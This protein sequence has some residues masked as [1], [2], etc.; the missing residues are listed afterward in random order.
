LLESN[1]LVNPNPKQKKRSTSNT[2][3][4]PSEKLKEDKESRE[5]ENENKAKEY[6]I[7]QG[8]AKNLCLSENVQMFKIQ[9]MKLRTELVEFLSEGIMNNKSLKSLIVNN[10]NL[11]NEAYEILIKG[12][13]THES[14]EFLDLSYNKLNDK[15]GN[16]IARIIS[17]Q[18]QRRDQVVWMYGL[19]NERPLGN[20]YTKGLISINLSHNQ[21]SDISAE[22][23]SLALSHDSYIRSI[24]L[25]HNEISS[26]GCK[27]LI[28]ILRRN[29]SLLNLDLR[30][31]PG[32]ENGSNIHKR[33]VVKLSKN[34]KNLHNQYLDEIYSKKEYDYIK[35]FV[36]F[37]FF[38][39]EIP[40]HIVD[41]Y[42]SQVEEENMN[43]N[44][45]NSSPQGENKLSTGDFYSNKD[46]SINNFKS[47]D[48]S[49]SGGEGK[50]KSSSLD[51]RRK[52]NKEMKIHEKDG[53]QINKKILDE[54]DCDRADQDLNDMDNYPE[55]IDCD[56]DENILQDNLNYS[57]TDEAFQAT[58][59]NK[60]LHRVFSKIKEQNKTLTHDNLQLRKQIVA[61]RAQLLQNLNMNKATCKF[62]RN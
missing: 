14:I 28:K 45:L 51:E 29:V 62:L 56:E 44:N 53:R 57:D 50:K 13:L 11:T 4:T 18:T 21:L 6:Q 2:P 38:N 19:R 35:Q 61:L 10:C 33:L 8:I 47:Q 48:Q 59:S 7:V 54:E 34:L 16:M 52:I 30:S 12:L 27:K 41:L 43:W 37:D 42:Y 40:E 24:N 1:Q 39:V 31:N 46:E 55:M 32:Y 23:I 15:C 5:R 22:D 17:R 49:A 20:D 3:Q 25:G 58:D 36:N 9:N 26:E 60:K